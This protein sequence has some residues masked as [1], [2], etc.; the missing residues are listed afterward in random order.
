M[1]CSPII[2][3]I[4]AGVLLGATGLYQALVPSGISGILDACT[5]F[6]SAPTSALI[7]LAIG[8]DLVLDDIPWKA[9]CAVVGLRLAIMAVLG[10]LLLLALHALW[11]EMKADAAVLVMFLMPPPFV[12]PVFAKGTEQRAYVS[13]ALSVSTLVAIIGFT[14]LAAAGIG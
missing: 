4:A 7:L 13:A 2:A 11:P 3:A 12:L 10:G 1:L 9:T 8:Y 6:V 14:V 5:D